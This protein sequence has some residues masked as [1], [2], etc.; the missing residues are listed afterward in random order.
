MESPFTLSG[1]DK[2]YTGTRK[3]SLYNINIHTGEIKSSFGNTDE[4]PIPRSTLPP[5]TA[6][7][8]D[9]T[10]M[11]GKTTYELSIHSKSNSDVM[12]NVTYSQW[13]PNNIDNDLI[14]QNQQSLD[15]I[16]FTPFHDRSLLAINKDIGTP[17]WISKLP[18]LPVSI[19]MFSAIVL[20]QMIICYCPSFESVE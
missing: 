16:Y 11:I 4:C 6:F 12:W 3:T 18:G 13:V 20:K 1:D 8:A 2:I 5:E 15:K 14:L 9:D 10:I 7:N 17:I 19:L